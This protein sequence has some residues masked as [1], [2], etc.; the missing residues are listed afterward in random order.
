MTVKEAKLSKKDKEANTILEILSEYWPEQCYTYSSE[1]GIIDFPLGMFIGL[2]DIKKWLIAIDFTFVT[3]KHDTIIFMLLIKDIIKNKIDIEI[4]SG[5]QT[6]L[7]KKGMYKG[8]IMQ[9][10]IYKEQEEKNITEKEA[11]KIVKKTKMF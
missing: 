1:N 6:L 10:D 4:G 3:E 8:L 9:Y 7:N 11:E 5:Y 2:N